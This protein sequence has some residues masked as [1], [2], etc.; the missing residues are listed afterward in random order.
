MSSPTGLVAG[1]GR[2]GI[3]RVDADDLRLPALR[4]VLRA[5]LLA[6]RFAAP[7]F[8]AA[9]LRPPLLRALVFRD[10]PAREPAARL[11]FRAALVL[12][13]LDALRLRLAFDFFL[14]R[15]GILLLREQCSQSSGGR[16]KFAARRKGIRSA[17]ARILYAN[18]R[19]AMTKKYRS[20]LGEV[21]PEHQPTAHPPER[22]IP[23]T[24][25]GKPL[26]QARPMQPAAIAPRERGVGPLPNPRKPK[27]VR[28]VHGNELM[29]LFEF[30]PDLPRP[31]RKP[32][33]LPARR[34]RRF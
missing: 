26:A 11:V 12:R 19:S 16:S 33:R 22:A 24:P 10:A 4:L 32:V 17:A 30:F 34:R 29:D 20:R 18:A 9:V 23:R 27:L 2:A 28:D 7:F 14:P 8:E 13:L 1:D 25:K 15:G 31:R 3:R 21:P 6:T 5:L